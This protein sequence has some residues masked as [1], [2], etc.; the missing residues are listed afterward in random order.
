MLSSFSCTNS[1]TGSDSSAT[2]KAEIPI[3]HSFFV[4]GPVLTGIVGEAGEVLWDAG[5]P[6]ARDG[7]VLDNGH[8]LICWSDEVK[9]YDQDKNVVFTF[10]KSPEN[11]E[12]GTV[13]RLENGNTL[14]TEL[15]AQA[16]LLEVNSEGELL[17]NVPLQPETDNAHM[18]TRMARKLANGNYLVPHLLAFAVK[19][20]TPKGEVVNTFRT[21]LPEIGGREAEN[22]PFTAIRLKNGNTLVNLTHGNK[23]V[24]MDP[25]GKVVW[26]VS[27][28]DIEGAPFKDPCGAQRLPNGNTV[29]A[30]Y[31]AQEGI[32]LFEVNP[33]KEMVWSYDGDYRVHHFQILSTNGEKLAG[34][35]LK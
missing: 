32:K 34:P 23:T 18:Q 26:Q 8:I 3:Q 22:W 5:K 4:A 27:N 33:Q 1:K 2:E 35:L 19:E 13:Q 20:Y 7:Y 24:E 16:R 29:I 15:G 30:S 25:T 9:E 12:L 31:G 28:E 17:V 14:I 11:K 10:K 21:D 6:G